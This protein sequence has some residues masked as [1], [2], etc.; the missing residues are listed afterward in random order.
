MN[1]V[2]KF[3]GLMV[4]TVAAVCWATE[5][6]KIMRRNPDWERG[7][8]TYMANCAA[9]H[10]NDPS[11]NGS[12]G[13]AIKGSS[14]A[15]LEYRVLGPKYPPGYTPKRNTRIM[16]AFPSLKAEV[17]YLAEYLR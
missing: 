6:E 15:L 8:A 14:R 9:C 13:P 4:L 12:I 17:P 2:G 5:P 16:P 11:M 10:N 7:R 3:I 1:T